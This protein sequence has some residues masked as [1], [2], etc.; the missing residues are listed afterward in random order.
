MQTENLSDFRYIN[1]CIA[2]NSINPADT[3]FILYKENYISF[4]YIEKNDLKLVDFFSLIVAI[5][6]ELLNKELDKNEVHKFATRC[7]EL[8]R[9]NVFRTQQ[10]T[11]INIDKVIHIIQN[12]R[13][14]KVS[15]ELNDD[16][17][18]N[19][20]SSIINSKVYNF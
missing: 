13:L 19:A 4:Y 16:L 20:D 5:P 15:N 18:F 12:T 3:L 8:H 7:Y 2:S 11:N 1:E 9:K 14:K 17:L 10:I 6:T